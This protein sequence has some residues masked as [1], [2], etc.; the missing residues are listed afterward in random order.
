MLADA[1]PPSASSS[2]R[3]PTSQRSGPAHRRAC[4]RAGAGR[5]RAGTTTC[6]QNRP[7]DPTVTYHMNRLQGLQADREFCVTL[8][9]T[10][11]DRPGERHPHHRLR[12]PRLHPEGYAAQARHGE[13]SGR[14]RTHFC[15]AYWSWGF[16]EDGV[17]SACASPSASAS[18]DI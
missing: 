5:G 2:A 15:G 11:G 13:I 1:D 16:H 4:S 18:V 14:N 9:H 12:A 7:V 17:A 10:A 3:S 6:S 8:N